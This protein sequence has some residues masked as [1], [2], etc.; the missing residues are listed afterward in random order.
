MVVRRDNRE[1]PRSKDVFYRKFLQPVID[2]YRALGIAAEY[3]PVNDVV[4][5][6]RKISARAWPK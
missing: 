4:V 2:T 1:V 6:S 5:E 3:K